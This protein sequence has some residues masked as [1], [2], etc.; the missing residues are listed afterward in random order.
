MLIPVHY[1]SFGYAFDSAAA[2]QKRIYSFTV[3]QTVALS[4]DIATIA[5]T[6]T[7]GVISA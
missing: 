3:E 4:N 7:G 2:M 1:S 6:L 5:L